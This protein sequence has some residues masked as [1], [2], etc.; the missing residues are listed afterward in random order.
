MAMPL[1]HL[2]A[3]ARRLA[4]PPVSDAE[5]LGRFVS[6][7]DEAALATLVARHGPMV[8]HLCRRLLFD[9]HAAED[10][11]QATFMVLA[12]KAGSIGRPASLLAGFMVSHSAWR[13]RHAVPSVAGLAPQPA[14]RSKCVI[15]GAA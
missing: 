13:S 6:R 2:L 14:I 10:A 8:L 1:T 15:Q 3:E 7:R 5:L 4:V 12:R 9:A 11:F